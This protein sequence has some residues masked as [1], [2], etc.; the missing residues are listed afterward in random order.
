MLG[1]SKLAAQSLAPGVQEQRRRE[2]QRTQRAQRTAPKEG[3]GEEARGTGPF[4]RFQPVP[5]FALFAFFAVN[6]LF[7]LPPKAHD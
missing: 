5:F 1:K 3:S 2:P 4:C 6:R 7:V